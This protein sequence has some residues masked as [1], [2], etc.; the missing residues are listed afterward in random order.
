ML[1]SFKTHTEANAAY[2]ASSG[3]GTVRKQSSA[4]TLRSQSHAWRNGLWVG[5]IKNSS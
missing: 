1:N 5:E 2:S 4:A 3:W